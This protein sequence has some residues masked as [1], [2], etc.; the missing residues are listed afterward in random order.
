[1]TTDPHDLANS[2]QVWSRIEYKLDH[3]GTANGILLIVLGLILIS[4]GKRFMP[5]TLFVSG[6]VTAGYLAFLA[7]VFIA[8]EANASDDALAYGSI[9]TGSIAGLVGG[10]VACNIIPVGLF[11]IGAGGGAAFGS[12][13]QGLILL[14]DG[15]PPPYLPYV[16]VAVCALIGGMFMLKLKLT[17][18]AVLASFLGAVCVT[19]GWVFFANYASMIDILED[20]GGHHSDDEDMDILLQLTSIVVLTIVGSL[21]Q[22]DT[23]SYLC[24]CCRSRRRRGTF[25]QQQQSLLNAPPADFTEAVSR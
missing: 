23:Y 10:F 6:F 3:L 8:D 18:Y 12:Y 11:L 21:Y 14:A 7:F 19:Q 2:S 1:M 24:L 15:Q 22:T 17:L 9:V 4:M 16:I 13:L 20:D 25:A 5:L